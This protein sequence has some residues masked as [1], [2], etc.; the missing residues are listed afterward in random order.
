MSLAI[1]PLLLGEVE[2]DFSFLVWQTK[3]GTPTYVPATA[4]LITGADKP[5]L[6]DASFRTA[7]DVTAYSGL[8]ARRSDDQTLEAQLRKHNLQPADIG[9]LIHTHLHLD[10]CGLDDQ[11]PNAKIMLQRRELQYAA[12]PLFPVP[13]YDRQDIAALVGKLWDRV[14]ILDEEGELFPGIRT[15]MTGGHT[16][17]HQMVYVEVPSGTAIITGDAAYLVDINVKQQVPFGYYVNLTEVM[18]G[19]KRIAHDGKHILPTH[20]ISV[21]ERYAEGVK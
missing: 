3:C 14:E 9:Y 13:F 19:L 4:W 21:H 5:I 16:P 7:K 8:N 6:V 2:V 10:H 17:A 18:A 11:L 20:D 1:Y 12:A 15:V